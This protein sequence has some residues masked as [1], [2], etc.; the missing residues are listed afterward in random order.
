VTNETGEDVVGDDNHLMDSQTSDP[1][2]DLALKRTEWALER[3]QLAWVRT[4]F[5]MM[6]AGVTL[7]KGIDAL[8]EAR[9]LVGRQW[10]VGGQV[11][12]VLLVVAAAALL[13]MA[14]AGYVRRARELHRSCDQ[15]SERIPAA[16]L[17]S[18]LVV[19]LGVTVAVLL[20][21]WG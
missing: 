6:T 18:V 9:L 8:F 3:T 15:R 1:R 10:V 17:L 20:V 14:T 11:G 2:V 19:L 7:D 21:L 4:A 16:L 13:A 5:V 12:G